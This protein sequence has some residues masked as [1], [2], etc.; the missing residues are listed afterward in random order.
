MPRTRRVR[1]LPALD[2]NTLAARAHQALLEAILTGKM[3]PGEHLVEMALCDELGVSRFSVRDAF[4]ELARDGLIEIVPNRGAFIVELTPADIAE[5]FQLRAALES[6]CVELA[7]E[8]ATPE[9]MAHLAAV[10][11][12]MDALERQN[13]RVT[14]AQIDTEFH[15]GLM[16]CSH[17]QRA[18]QVWEQMSAQITLVVYSVSN[19]YPA[20]GGF[21]GRHRALLGLMRAHDGDSAAAY[22]RNHILEG[23]QSLIAAHREVN[24]PENAGAVQ[25]PLTS[26]IAIKP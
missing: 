6:F 1:D 5:I 3:K 21:A 25:D 17:H 22:V 8:R 12:Q 14:G 19:V 2:R 4:R 7:A 13:D 18:I 26:D 10:V 20:F 23:G 15:R 9:D 11:E 24:G 16:M